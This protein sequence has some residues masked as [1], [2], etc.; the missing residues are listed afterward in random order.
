MKQKIE[1]FAL[2]GLKKSLIYF[3]FEATNLFL[4]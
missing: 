1:N 4:W 2:S 3:S